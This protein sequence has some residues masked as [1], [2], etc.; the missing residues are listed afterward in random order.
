MRSHE[1]MEKTDAADTV[2]VALAYQVRIS[3]MFTADLTFPVDHDLPA[4][5]Y[6]AHGIHQREWHLICHSYTDIKF[7][8]V[9]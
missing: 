8:K 7:I 1:Q 6:V 3:F 5:Y 2:N 9:S 4:E